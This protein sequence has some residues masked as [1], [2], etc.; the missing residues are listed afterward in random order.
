MRGILSAALAPL[1]LA[2]T[3]LLWGSGFRAMTIGSQHTH[4]LMVSALRMA[5]ATIALVALLP[6]LGSRLPRDRRTW[7]LAATSGVLGVSLTLGAIPIATDLAGSA[8]A[9]VLGNS[10]P[11][12]MLLIGRVMLRERMSPL[13]AGGM[14]AAFAGVIVMVSSQLG[15]G[16]GTG[17]LVGGMALAALTAVA[18]AVSMAIVKSQLARDADIDLVALSAAQHVVG[19][20]LLLAV[21]F[22][23]Y[24]TGGTD[25]GSGGLW[26]PVLWLGLGAS[27]IGYASLYTA[28][29]RM[30]ASKASAWM[31]LVPVVAVVI[32]VARG[33]V[34]GAVQLVGIVLTIAG[35]AVANVAPAP[36]VRMADAGR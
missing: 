28:M 9:S 33:N 10:T 30:P 27:A 13:A 35:V 7:L 23:V 1:L 14:A 21:G 17:S 25:W 11:L 3:M 34:P 2:G 5:P 22:A 6:L 31:F 8:N 12:W 16:S 29:R 20:P 26:G 4:P 15:G 32:E 18:F 24:G 19:G 36:A